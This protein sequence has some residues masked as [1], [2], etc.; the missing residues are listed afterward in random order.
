MERKT[1]LA[2]GAAAGAGFLIACHQGLAI[3]PSP[4]LTLAAAGLGLAVV[5]S[6]FPDID[7][8]TSKISQATKP[9]SYIVSILFGHRTLFHSPLLYAAL[10]FLLNHFFPNHKFLILAFTTGALSHLLIDMLNAKGIPLFYPSTRHYHFARLKTG[11]IADRLL[12]ICLSAV[13]V[14]LVGMYFIK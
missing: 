7:L 11:G 9:V 14:V 5:G 8:R 2:G 10:F 12:T 13:A 3:V 1:H 4:N 6:L